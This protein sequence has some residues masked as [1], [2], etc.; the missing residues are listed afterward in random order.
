VGDICLLVG[1]L[2]LSGLEDDLSQQWPRCL[3]G[4]KRAFRVVGALAEVLR[5]A[6]A[7]HQAEVVLMD[8]GPNLGAINRAALIAADHVIVPLGPDLFS[9]KGLQNLGPTLRRWREQWQERLR[10]RPAG[11]EVPGGRMQ[12]AGYVVMQHSVRL[13]RPVQAYARW[14]ARIPATYR[15]AVLGEQHTASP[16]MDHDPNCLAMLKDYRSLMPMAQEA[17]KPM[18]HLQ[19][20]GWRHR[21]PRAGGAGCYRDFRALAHTI[22]ERTGLET[23]DP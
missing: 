7:E 9:L 19:A 15:Q 6:A 12:P 22:A 3:D 10:K 16:A 20:R 11:I 17:R 5:R 13:D 18:F 23:S 8:V 14:M 1:D 21:R 4:D 2:A